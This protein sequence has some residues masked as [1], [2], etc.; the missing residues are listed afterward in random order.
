MFFVFIKILKSIKNQAGQI[1]KNQVSNSS[2]L[3]KKFKKKQDFYGEFNDD[4]KSFW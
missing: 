3:I 4:L 2:N 1:A